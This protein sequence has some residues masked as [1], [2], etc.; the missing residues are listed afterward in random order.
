MTPKEKAEEIVNEI[1]MDG[2]WGE[3]ERGQKID[4]ATI[5]VAKIFQAIKITTDHCTLSPLDLNGVRQDLKFW[6]EVLVALQDI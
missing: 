3:L 4:Y 6:D 2:A 1:E 5:V